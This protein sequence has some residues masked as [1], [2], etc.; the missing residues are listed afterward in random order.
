MIVPIMHPTANPGEKIENTL[1]RFAGVDVSDA[2]ILTRT[3]QGFK[4]TVIKPRRIDS[5]H[6]S[7]TALQKMMAVTLP[8]KPTAPAAPIVMAETNQKGVASSIPVRQVSPG[9]RYHSLHEH[10]DAL[11]SADVK[12]DSFL[13]D[14]EAGDC[15]CDEGKH[16]SVCR[17]VGKPEHENG[18]QTSPW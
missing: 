17:S 15:L 6:H 12:T 16:Y 1:L 11:R 7:Q 3:P 10:H 9:G 18:K 5:N 14:V 4:P 8:L 13:R 2:R